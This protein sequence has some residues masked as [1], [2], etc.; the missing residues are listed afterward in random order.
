VPDR[1]AAGP[2]RQQ[3]G[4]VDVSIDELDERLQVEFDETRWLTLDPFGD[5]A[6]CAGLQS[7][8]TT[9]SV[10][11]SRRAGSGDVIS[12]GLS[13]QESI[14]GSG[15]YNADLR[16]EL[17]DGSVAQST[18]TMTIESGLRSGTFLTFVDES[19]DDVGGSLSGAFNC[20]GAE[21]PV[22]LERGLGDAVV[23]TVEV[24]V[25]LADGDV[26]RV[27]GL[28]YDGSNGI[29]L[30]PGIEARNDPLLVQVAGNRTL[31]SLTMFELSGG[32][33][34]SMAMTSGGVTY[35]F[36]GVRVDT[37]PG[38]TSGSF[39]GTTPSGLS[40]DGAFRCT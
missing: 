37:S 18:G 40:A 26:E 27:V 36:N 8:I 5:F 11:V 7:A 4:T 38:A 12:V 24:F 22:P 34:A 31:G 20:E 33:Q 2:T 35:E 21:E 17:A 10:L 14:V 28:I 30:C 29:A 9:Y 3:T 16:V 25:L 39:S 6:S 32:S 23:D 19:G 13:S 1:S 15:I